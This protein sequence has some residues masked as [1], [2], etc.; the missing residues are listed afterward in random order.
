MR[1]LMVILLGLSLSPAAWAVSNPQSF[2][3]QQKTEIQTIVHDYLLEKPEILVEVAKKLQQKKQAEVSA[4]T[5]TAIA[6][7]KEAIFDGK[8]PI[9]GNPNGKVSIVEFFDYQ[10]GHCQSMAP[11]LAALLNKDKSV[12]IVYKEL[13]IF[14]DVS[15]YAAKAALAANLQQK[16]QAVHDA[17]MAAP[18]GLTHEQILDIAKN[19][20]LDIEKLKVDIDSPAITE[21][22]AKN[23]TLAENLGIMGTPAFIITTNPPQLDTKNKVVFISGEMPDE[24]LEEIVAK[25]QQ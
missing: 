9:T 5:E 23:K 19:S 20:G 14:G 25:V 10:C 22:L 6:K 13:P 21:A 18:R 24:K 17:L 7:N 12:Q 1:R 15:T 8:S 3:E 16:Y 11:R 4:N 2:N